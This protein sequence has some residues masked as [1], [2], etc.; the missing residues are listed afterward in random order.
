MR[1]TP[2][3]T[4]HNSTAVLFKVLNLF[5]DTLHFPQKRGLLFVNNT[6]PPCK[7]G[8]LF[9]YRSFLSLGFLREVEV[10]MDNRQNELDTHLFCIL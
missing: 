4:N 1:Q 5:L 6:F 8:I 3:G 9:Q 7:I 2:T 10:E